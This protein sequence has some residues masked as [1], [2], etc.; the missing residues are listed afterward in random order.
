MLSSLSDAGPVS[1]PCALERLGLRQKQFYCALLEPGKEPQAIQAAECF[2]SYF[3]E[4][5]PALAKDAAKNF[6]YPLS[7]KL[8]EE[9]I[10]PLA[11]LTLDEAFLE[12]DRAGDST[13][14]RDVFIKKQ[15]AAFPQCCTV[16][17]AI[18]WNGPR[19][20][21]SSTSDRIFP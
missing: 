8:K 3:E 16:Q 18:L 4:L 21:S 9:G 12:L 17:A 6:L 15:P 14:L 1:L 11:A 5:E 19:S 13:A 20:I 2:A 10:P 7:I